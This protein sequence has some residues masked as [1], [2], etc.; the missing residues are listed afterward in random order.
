[1]DGA[2]G[3]VVG[4]IKVR[5]KPDLTGFRTELETQL[6]RIEQQV[7]GTV[8]VNA[9]FDANGLSEK[10]QT[11]ARAAETDVEVGTDLDSA[12]LA[13]KVRSAAK[14]AE[15]DVKVGV[16]SPSLDRFQQ[17]MLATVRSAFSR[18]EPKLDLT[19]DGEYIR[20]QFEATEQRINDNIRLKIPVTF[21]DAALQRQDV[22]RLVDKAVKLD[23]SLVPPLEF[24]DTLLTDKAKMKLGDQIDKFIGEQRDKELTFDN[25]KLSD[26]ALV[27]M[28]QRIDKFLGEIEE[29]RP[30]VQIDADTKR[31]ESRIK[32]N[33]G[34]LL[35]DIQRQ[36]AEKVSL[37]PG[38]IPV[39][40]KNWV[41]K[42]Q[43]LKYKADVDFAAAEF[44]LRAFEREVSSARLELA[45]T[46]KYN[47]SKF[48]AARAQIA[49]FMKKIDLEIDVDRNSFTRIA[50]SL[51][52]IGAAGTLATM[53]GLGSTLGTVKDGA[54]GAAKG[55]ASL[56]QTGWIVLAV[57]ALLSPA[58][59]LLSGILVTIPAAFA[60][61]TIP[62]GAIALGMDGIKKAAERAGL[63][64]DSKPGKKGGGK[65]GEALQEIKKQVSDTFENALFPA[66]EKI[67]AIAE[68]VTKPMANVAQGLSDMF[69][70][71]IDS[72]ASDDGK[73]ALANTI[74]NLGD[75]FSKARPGMQNF[76]S[77]LLN[78]VSALSN[79]FPGLAEAFNRTGDSFLKWVDKITTK[80]PV[81][82][83][84]Q[85]DTAMRTL[86]DTLSGLGGL[87][88]D[89]FRDGFK[90][91]S[92]PSFGDSMKGFISDIRSLV[93]NVLPALAEAFQ[94]IATALKPI[95][96]TVEALSK[97]I[98][99]FKSLTALPELPGFKNPDDLGLFDKIKFTWKA[100][101]GQNPFEDL[102]IKA[103]DAGKQSS[104]QF[105]QGWLGGGGLFD[106]TE[107]VRTQLSTATKTAQ[108][109]A[110]RS[111]FNGESVGGAVANQLS[112]QLQS[113]LS[114]ADTAVAVLGP[115]LQQTMDTAL[116][117]VLA[118]PVKVGQAFG[119]AAPSL[120][121]AF[122]V[123]A[124]PAR[125]GA[126]QV[127]DAFTSTLTT[128][129][130]SGANRAAAAVAGAI[131]AALGSAVSTAANMAVGMVQAMSAA[132][133]ALPGVT[134]AWFGTVPAAIQ[135]AMAPAVT[136]V[137]DMCGQI[138]N[139]M[140]SYV[141]AAE[142][143]GLAIGASF[144]KGLYSSASLVSN[145]ANDLMGLARALFPNSPAKKGP[146][147][148]SGWVDKS[149]E[150]VGV[151]F[152]SGIK[153]SSSG[154]LSTA[155][156]LMQAIKDI[157]GSAEGLTLNFNFG[158]MTSGLSDVS[159]SMGNV[160]KSA[161]T[162][163]DNLASAADI[164]QSP[165]LNLTPAQM[166]AQSDELSR[167]LNLLEQ[168]RKR[169]EI[170]KGAGELSKEAAAARLEEIRQQKLQLGLQKDQLTYAQKYGD[171][172][173][174]QSDAQ[175]AM[176]DVMKKGVQTPIDLL[177]A[178]AQQWMSDL[179]M[180]GNGAIPTVANQLLGWGSSF[181][182]NVN[183]MDDALSAQQTLQNKQSMGYVGR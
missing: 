117:P 68:A 177:T 156:E 96:A 6:E 108:A 134:Q 38:F 143:S 136:A 132:W 30:K 14:A 13:A 45:L 115:K 85:L 60:A 181:I 141:G 164:S 101:T 24:G 158:A 182:F 47:Y 61:F 145:A 81:T 149:G 160:A 41:T 65:L 130:P 106:V 112:T 127:A 31:L 95:T 77:G 86:G 116:E 99:G 53:K 58:L 104:E 165:Q 163:T 142:S 135:G 64:A 9:D 62:I 43:L 172:V 144:A 151:G 27:R 33:V 179:G 113:V 35:A 103:G 88:G 174:G 168:E 32:T 4:S 102:V 50:A 22:K 2:D 63:F 82:Q 133:S 19:P 173:G 128:Q 175:K 138:I 16:D 74:N 54:I 94:G 55:L 48:L 90:N 11:A 105:G 161:Q 71:F 29:A 93:S 166:K 18:I 122:T 129:M 80:D 119:L 73:N 76:T 150:A 15:T 36:A 154:V 152:A 110:L 3:N 70:G 69:G 72:L 21:D 162:Y 49:A 66:F 180:S 5:V 124:G 157:F 8:K 100:A 125:A 114:Q 131:G 12:G 75:A 123:L 107:A 51:A 26:N 1:M 79:K 167:Q 87:V 92:D 34:K 57:V 126:Q 98:G 170:A 52:G 109:D 91:L 28:G 146:F 176:N 37:E 39:D 42:E 7:Q 178:N 155:K 139:T 169:I 171:Q 23:K 84:S 44:K 56:S 137:A 120:Q 67:P 153:D 111:A 140:L 10:V 83:V 25:T 40:P 121:G 46:P 78:L 17:R 183:N 159:S 20:R 59:A 148:G 118:L 89:F 147:S 97:L